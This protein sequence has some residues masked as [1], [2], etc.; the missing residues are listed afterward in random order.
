MVEVIP[1]FAR[2][3]WT[4]GL[5][6]HS[7][8]AQGAAWSFQKMRIVSVPGSSCSFKLISLFLFIKC[9]YE[10]ASAISLTKT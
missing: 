3:Y 5:S 8:L 1:L 7:N 4:V 6:F 9:R 10:A 2:D